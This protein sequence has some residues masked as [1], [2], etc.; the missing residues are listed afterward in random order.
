[1]DTYGNKKESEVGTNFELI[2]CHDVTTSCE[3]TAAHRI[4]GPTNHVLLW[5][6]P[7]LDSGGKLKL[8]RKKEK[9][10]RNTF[11]TTVK[12][13]EMDRSE[14]ESRTHQLDPAFL[15]NC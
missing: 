12:S 11:V 6:F 1:M 15:G 9:N 4:T 7:L 2:P 14:I 3:T 10:K 5:R 13:T 8:G